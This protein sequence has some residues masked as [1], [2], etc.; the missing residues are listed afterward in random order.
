VKR[1][2][3]VPNCNLKLDLRL[4]DRSLAQDSLAEFVRQA[5]HVVE[6]A[7][8]IQWNWHLDVICEYLEAVTVGD[9]NRL[10][11]N[12]PPR[13]GK[14]ILASVM[15]P[16]WV[17]A[18]QPSA[19][20]LCAS[21]SAILANKLSTDRRTVLTSPWYQERWPIQ[22]ASDQNQKSEFGNT[23][24]GH[25]I[26]TS[27][28]G[29]ATGRGGDFIIAD[30]LQNPD[31]A[32]SKLERETVNRFFDETLSTR[33][34][35]KR[36]GRIVVIQQ[37]T[38]QADLTGHLLEQ[39]GWTQLCLPA[40]FE[41][42]RAIAIPRSRREIVKLDGDLLWPE[43]E[44]RA[45]LDAAKIRLGPY[46]YACQYQQN[47]IARGGNLFKEKW[48]GTFRENPKF[49]V[50]VQSWDCAFKAG[51]TNDYSACATIGWVNPNREAATAAPGFYLVDA[52][53]GRV[54]FP[55]LKRRAQ[56][57]YEWWH[58]SVVLIEDTASGQ[59]LLQE[60]RTVLPIKG[61]IPGA[62][63]TARATAITPMI[64]NGQFW[65]LEGAPWFKDYIEEMTGFP[66]LAHDDFVDATVQALTYL[67]QPEPPILGYY[68]DRAAAE[69]VREQTSGFPGVS[70]YELAYHRLQAGTCHQ[71]G[72]TLFMKSSV[73]D[74]PGQLC[75]DCFN[76][77]Q[78]SRC[79]AP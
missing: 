27:V 6:P 13:S 29:S 33:L 77:Q 79:E 5:W 78:R 25:M 24:R 46:G 28:S 48:F 9:I 57:L 67:R 40:E 59:S 7:T 63:K 69:K 60:L 41:R 20:W 64:E 53:R 71:C 26:A 11:I 68:R 39:G 37:R 34:D 21:Y 22:L 58:P 72:M 23:D 2:I 15:W 76:E 62:D 73:T 3:K 56:S 31:M 32:E 54:E 35:D 65:L 16:A 70:T 36:H 51:Q 66:G 52:W 10:I 55:D 17:W 50:L 75:M 74:G 4:L 49:D 45:E 30:D 1:W 8:N 47:P 42:R 14:S 38:H 61:I 18:R 12:L 19:R 43:R 44:G